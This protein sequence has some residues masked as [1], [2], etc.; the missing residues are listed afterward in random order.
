LVTECRDI[1]KSGRDGPRPLRNQGFLGCG[2]GV[3]AGGC[4][5]GAVFDCGGAGAGVIGAGFAGA[6][7][8]FENF[9]RI[10]L[11]CPVA[12]SVRNTKAMAQIMNIT[13]HQ[14]VA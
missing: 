9:S 12:L 11:P 4:G 1:E 5:A 6:G 14:V 2:A 3:L 7:A 8:G 13:A 10:E